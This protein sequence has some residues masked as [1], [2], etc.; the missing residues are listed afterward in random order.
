[1][2]DINS[3]LLLAL[4]L[5]NEKLR[6]AIDAIPAA[7]RKELQEIRL[8]R[9]KKLSAVAYG[10]EYFVTSDGRLMR[11]PAYALDV[12][13]SDIMYTYE[14]SLEHSVY[15][16]EREIS[17][18]YVTTQGGNRVGFCGK[19]VYGSEGIQSLKDISSVNIRIS[20]E[21]KGCA[22]EIFSRYYSGA[23]VSLLITGPPS[24]GKTTLLRDLCSKLSDK[25]TV[26]LIDERNE[27]ASVYNGIP[28]N[29]VGQRTDIFCSYDKY[30]AI[31]TSIRVMSPQIIICDEIG[32]G[33]EL[34][35]LEY[36]LNS[37]V[38][39]I[40]TCHAGDINEVRKRPVISK[41]IK[42]KAFD[43]AVILSDRPFVGKPE[44]FYELK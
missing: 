27:I 29:D 8:R 20:R 3:K 2:S 32:G 34:K 5:L 11:S 30:S 44:A 31:M 26:S 22:N 37:G 17:H 42:G 7:E 6:R 9:G 33:D 4:N 38:K 18:G 28:Q 15:A 16:Y 36:A 39:L 41:L 23:P 40:A 24:S 1:M 21:V 14:A 12:T 10:F 19:A 35:A 43:N 13:D 25:Y